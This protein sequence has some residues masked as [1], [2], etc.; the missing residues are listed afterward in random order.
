MFGSNKNNSNSSTKMISKSDA[1]V[2]GEG[3]IIKGE[4]KESGD[5]TIKGRVIGNLDVEG[6]LILEDGG[7]VQGNMVCKD[8]IIRGKVD[9]DVKV[10]ENLRLDA[11][12]K[13]NG[14]IEYKVISV[15]EGA[16]FNGN[17]KSVSL[18]QAKPEKN[19]EKKAEQKDQKQSQG[20]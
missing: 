1:T 9:G 3:C 18:N 10:K 15:E 13:I 6:L 12:A 2:I 16:A 19:I 11:P 20:K 7:S 4:I 14:D 8:A 17:C 5:I